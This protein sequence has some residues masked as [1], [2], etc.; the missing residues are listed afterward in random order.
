MKIRVT[1]MTENDK[2]LNVSKEEIE[3]KA[4]IGWELLCMMFNNTYGQ[5]D[6]ATVEKCE[7]VEM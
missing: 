2:H 4:K 5:E 3:E 6:V 1:L 7:L